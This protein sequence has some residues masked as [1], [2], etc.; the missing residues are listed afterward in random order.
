MMTLVG[1]DDKESQELAVGARRRVQA[2]RV[3]AEDLL[4]PLLGLVHDPKR[5]LDLGGMLQ[6]VDATRVL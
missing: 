1:P 3:H 6:W 2:N 5:A 4:E